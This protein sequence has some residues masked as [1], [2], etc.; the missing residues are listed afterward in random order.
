MCIRDSIYGV[1]NIASKVP[2]MPI[3]LGSY[4]KTTREI[5]HK[6]MNL[7]LNETLSYVLVLLKQ[8]RCV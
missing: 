3:K 8:Y 7:G 1:D 5:R 6:M 2:V 4:D